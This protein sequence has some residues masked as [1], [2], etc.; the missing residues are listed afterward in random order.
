MRLPETEIG[1]IGNLIEKS[2][3]ILIFSHKSPDGDT[4]GSA[5]ALFQAFKN[6]GKEPAL[7]CVD[8][9]PPVY[10]F[11][12][13]IRAFQQTVEALDY[14]AYFIVD[15]GAY[16]MTDF[17]TALPAVF[18]KSLET[19]NIDHHRSNELFGK[20]NLVVPDAPSTTMILAELFK[21]LGIP[22]DRSMATSLLTGI[23]TDTGSFMHSNTTPETYRMAAELLRRGANLRQISKEIFNTTPISTLR[24]WGMVL[25]NITQTNDNVTMS[26]VSQK[27]FER[28]GADPSE[29]SGVIDYVNSVPGAK[30]SVILTE[31]G[32]KVK[33]SL[34]T[35][36]DDVDVA[37]IAS[38][39]GGGGHIKAAGFSIAGKLEKEIRW[40]V[41][42]TK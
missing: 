32:E 5:T 15:S 13:N 16:Y 25:K 2:H 19:V 18:D 21:T 42:D 20:H 31:Q 38:Q 10:N 40:K 1:K 12:P 4:L 33:A 8:I 27:D 6:M 39:Y 22:V 3:R 36:R 29:M 28:A 14:D 37:Q 11:I 9:P 7:A 23:Y 35:L 26:V 34:R 41:V 30:Y 17:H 24:L